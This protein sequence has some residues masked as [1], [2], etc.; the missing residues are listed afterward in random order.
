MDDSSVSGRNTPGEPSLEQAL[1]AQLRWAIFASIAP[2]LV[3]ALR[4][5][6]RS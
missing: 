6:E 1:R 4:E 2:E 5:G 3:R